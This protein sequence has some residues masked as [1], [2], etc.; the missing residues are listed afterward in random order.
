MSQTPTLPRAITKALE[1]AGN[2]LAA[3]VERI[4]A[5]LAKAM[6]AIHGHDWRIQIEHEPGV[7][8][9]LVRPVV[10]RARP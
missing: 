3:D 4:A 9:V 6:K 7:E 5:Q 1:P 8:F 10:T 2:A